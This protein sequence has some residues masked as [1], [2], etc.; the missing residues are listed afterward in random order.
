MVYK[1]KEQV[2]QPNPVVGIGVDEFVFAGTIVGSHLLWEFFVTQWEQSAYDAYLDE[3]QEGVAMAPDDARIAVAH[4]KFT[5]ILI[6]A[7]ISAGLIGGA[8][9]VDRKTNLPNLVPKVMMGLGF[10]TIVNAF[11]NSL[12]FMNTKKSYPDAEKAYQANKE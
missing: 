7:G 9:L 6:Q 12:E 4:D 8:V 10:G 2:K 11:T 3:T 5:W 1:K